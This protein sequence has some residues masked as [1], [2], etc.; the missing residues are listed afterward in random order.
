MDRRTFVT[1][2]LGAGLG[3]AL[4]R[5]AGAAAPKKKAEPAVVVL[6]PGHGGRD[7]GAIGS[8]GLYEK[9][10][11]L[12][13]CQAIR[14]QLAGVRNLKVL[15]T[16][17]EDE[18]I[19]L[20]NRVAIAHEAD[21]D[22]FV[23]IHADAADSRGVRGLSAYTLSEKASDSFSASLAQRENAV[24]SLYGVDL[25]GTD[26][27][28]AAILMDLARRHSH[29]ASLNA[30]RRIVNGVEDK[31]HL[32]ENPMR[33]ANFAVLKSKVVPSVLVE[34]GFISNPQDEKILADRAGRARIAKALGDQI[35]AVALDLNRA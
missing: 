11:T 8:S 30:K 10:V 27:T 29:N 15:L 22:L 4:V 32:L 13:I 3:G 2:L 25:R 26:K 6:D 33:S 35:A 1:F 23:S 7:P 34:T 20:P 16:R 28:T 31:V 19:A 5:P 18:Y 9:H 17:N 24:D 14:S 21:A 12:A